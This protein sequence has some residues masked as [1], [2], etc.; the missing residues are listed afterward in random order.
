MAADAR[1]T[2]RKGTGARRVYDAVRERILTLAYE[3]GMNL[4]EGALVEEFGVS[5]TPVREAFIRL[6]SENL[7]T[8]LPNR[9]ARVPNLSLNNVR[10]FFEALSLTQRALT[11]WAALRSS[12]ERLVEVERWREAFEDAASSGDGSAMAVANR[13]FHIAVAHCAENQYLGRAYRELLDEG[14]RL[15][16]LAV[17]YDPPGER[18]RA[19]HLG[20]IIRE[21]RE[22]VAAIRS[23]DAERAEALGRA[24]A[25][26]FR[27]RVAEYIQ[28]SAA[29]EIDVLPA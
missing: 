26:L 2:G 11:R 14:M 1:D 15:S 8:I 16:R 13:E 20:T 27:C 24:H 17:L 10:Q 12:P 23:G 19:E 9:G 6:A 22:M 21:H 3:P 7:V 18:G 28:G 25:E 4:D 29:A 5:R